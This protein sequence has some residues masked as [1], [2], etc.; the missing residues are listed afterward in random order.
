MSQ[1]DGKSARSKSTIENQS[2]SSKDGGGRSLPKDS[3]NHRWVVERGG[4]YWMVL[5]DSSIEGPPPPYRKPP[6][7]VLITIVGPRAVRRNKPQ[8]ESRSLPGRLVIILLLCLDGWMYFL[9]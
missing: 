2:V 7:P 4:R 1:K 3:A 5:G 6:Q 8:S 9:P